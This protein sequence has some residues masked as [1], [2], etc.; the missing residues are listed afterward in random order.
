MSKTHKQFM[1]VCFY[2]VEDPPS[3]CFPSK[4]QIKL[5]NGKIV[6]MSEL[7][8]GDKVQTGNIKDQ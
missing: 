1:Q 5:E 6:T 4:T 8:T 2:F 7:K 3:K